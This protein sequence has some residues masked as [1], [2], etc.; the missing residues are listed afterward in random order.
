MIVDELQTL[1]SAHDTSETSARLARYVASHG[2]SIFARIDHTAGAAEVGLA[3]RPTEVLIYGNAKGGTPLMQIDQTFGMYLP[4]RA[5]IWQDESGR[6]WLSYYR[7]ES[8]AQRLP[9]NTNT[10]QIAAKL[11]GVQQQVA[12]HATGGSS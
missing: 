8:L 5:L 1:P 9:P 2:M 7:L 3:L 10:L 12:L 4:L 6:T 11:D